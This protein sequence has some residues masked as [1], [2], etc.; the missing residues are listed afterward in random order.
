MIYAQ[1][2]GLGLHGD[3]LDPYWD[4]VNNKSIYA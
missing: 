4:Y 3:A 2:N 1:R